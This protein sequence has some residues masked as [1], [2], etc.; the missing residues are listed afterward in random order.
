MTREDVLRLGAEL[1]I[2]AI[3]V[4]RAEAYVDGVWWAID[5]TRLA[6]MSRHPHPRLME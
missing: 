5:S 1:G 2:D 3:G 6:P 4:T